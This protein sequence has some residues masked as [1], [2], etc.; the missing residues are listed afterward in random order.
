MTNKLPTFWL[1]YQ[2]VPQEKNESTLFKLLSY[3]NG[4]LSHISP[5]NNMNIELS[6]E[7]NIGKV[8][9]PRMSELAGVQQLCCAV[10][11]SGGGQ[12]GRRQEGLLYIN[13]ARTPAP[14]SCSSRHWPRRSWGR[15]WHRWRGWWRSPWP[16]WSPR[17]APRAAPSWPEV[18]E[19]LLTTVMSSHC[20][21]FPKLRHKP[22]F[23]WTKKDENM[24]L[25]TFTKYPCRQAG[26]F[27]TIFVG[28]INSQFCIS[29]N[30][31]ACPGGYSIRVPV[32]IWIFGLMYSKMMLIK[33][34]CLWYRQEMLMVL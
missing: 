22:D 25:H 3:G 34:D 27:Y 18:R 13:T 16:P 2:V 33:I 5:F 30:I 6:S 17:P 26:R 9:F 21:V 31:P 28:S 8:S 1:G 20:I 11:W 19:T 12:G 15:C 29:K 10:Q 14:G 32:H 4:K 23:K 24:F 7:S